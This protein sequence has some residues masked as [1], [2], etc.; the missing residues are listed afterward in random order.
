MLA[1][2]RTFHYKKPLVA[3]LYLTCLKRCKPSKIDGTVRRVLLRWL[4][5]ELF[6]IVVRVSGDDNRLPS[7]FR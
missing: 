6:F 2:D 3:A 1:E 5:H 4:R 7:E